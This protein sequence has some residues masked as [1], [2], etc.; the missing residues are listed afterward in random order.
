MLNLINEEVAEGAVKFINESLPVFTKENI[1]AGIRVRIRDSKGVDAGGIARAFSS[2]VNAAFSK[3]ENDVGDSMFTAGGPANQY[4]LPSSLHIVQEPESGN[5]WTSFGKWL[6][7][8]L[9]H[10]FTFPGILHVS[11]IKYLFVEDISVEDVV[12][13]FPSLSEAF[14]GNS[15]SEGSQLKS[16]CIE[17]DISPSTYFKRYRDDEATA[18][19]KLKGALAHSILIKPRLYSLQCIANGFALSP[20]FNRVLNAT[21]F[22]KTCMASCNS[23]TSFMNS[24][25]GLSGT[26]SCSSADVAFIEHFKVRLAVVLERLS[27]EQLGQFMA[28]V[29]GSTVPPYDSK[30]TFNVVRSDSILCGHTCALTMD[31][32]RPRY[33]SQDTDYCVGVL[34]DDI[35]NKCLPANGENGLSF[36]IS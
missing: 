27:P 11:L 33:G 7:L 22:M 24:C 30:I 21:E 17:N 31:V 8:V 14:I 18:I 25:G 2:H 26:S 4:L 3:W 32:S 34:Y 35:V 1:M 13:F 36:Q 12:S 28:F 6:K 5:F 23:V 29:T 19:A 10:D 9:H 15:I 16:L 20:A